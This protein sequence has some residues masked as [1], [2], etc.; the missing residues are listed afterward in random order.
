VTTGCCFTVDTI[1]YEFQFCIYIVLFNFVLY[2]TFNRGFLFSPLL[3]PTPFY[4][5]HEKCII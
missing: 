2:T 3:Y 5:S 4:T 1:T